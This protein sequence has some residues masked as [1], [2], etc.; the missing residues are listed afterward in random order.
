MTPVTPP[1]K[2]RSAA[3]ERGET[4]AHLPTRVSPDLRHAES[5]AAP[6]LTGTLPDLFF[7]TVR[8]YP[9]N[10]ALMFKRSGVY[11]S[12]SYRELAERVK[13]LGRAFLKNGVQAGDRIA[14]MSENRP[15]W[16]V[17]DLAAVSIGAATVGIYVTLTPPQI[18]HILADSES[19]VLIVS[20]AKLLQK[21]LAIRNELPRLRFLA[22]LEPPSEEAR[23]QGVV[24]FQEWMEEGKTS[25][26]TLEEFDRRIAA[27]RPG[28]LAGLIYT[29]GTTGDPKGARL[30]HNNFHSNARAVPQVLPIRDEDLFLSFL[31]LCHV[32]ERLGGHYLPLS[33]GATIAYAESLFTVQKNMEETHP[34]IMLSV[35]RLYESMQQRILESAAKASPLK[36]RLLAWAIRTGRKRNFGKLDGRNNPLVELQYIAADALVLSKIREKLGGRLR[37]FVSGGA[38][39][40]KTTAE[41][42][43]ALGVTI[44]EGYGLTETSPVISVSRP[45]MIRFGTVGPPLPGVEVRIAEDGEILTR[46]PLVMEGY[47]NKPED[48]AQAID[49]EGWFRTGDIGKLDERGR[50]AIT[51]RKKDII[52]LANGKNVAPQPI[53]TA[54]KASRYIAEVALIGDRQNVVTALIV[55]AF[56][57]LKSYAKERNLD[58]PDNAALVK[59][60]EIRKLIKSEIDRHSVS[61]ADF[62]RVRRFTPLDHEWTLDSG[63]L[64]PTLKVKRKAIK[65]RYA[66]EIAEM[67][68]RED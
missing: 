19:L 63:L 53:E 16:A 28:D 18:R 17:T 11:Q 5:P 54:L 37:F 35:P 6:G 31:P 65:E 29:S 2:S 40:P 50:L 57:A 10:T 12:I 23:A 33:V 67:S 8:R 34:T 26:G 27:V 47:H 38:P 56:D 22:T 25:A 66:A 21:A 49:P 51:D 1:A 52:V 13:A 4:P 46:G 3:P 30:T 24:S 60:P 68:G 41:F 32:F 62:E 9:E 7:E 59:H 55:P 43:Y 14:I 48:T 58:V 44:L 39:L 64:T 42:F 45:E 61:F 15:E 20:D 36:R